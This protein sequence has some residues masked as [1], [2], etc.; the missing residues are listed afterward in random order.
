MEDDFEV[1]ETKKQSKPSWQARR[2]CTHTHLSHA[3]SSAHSAFTAYIAHLHAC[4]THAWFKVTKKVHCIC[5]VSLHLAFSLLMIHLSLLFLHG[6]FGTNP[7][8]DLT[9]SDIHMILPYFSVLKAQ[10][11]RH[12]APASRSLATWPSQMQTQVMNPT[13]STRSLPWMMTRCSSKIRTTISPTSR[14]NAYENIGLFGVPTVFESSV[15]HVSHDDVALQIESK[16]SMQSGNRCWAEGNRSKRRFCD[17]C[18]RIDVKEKSTEQYQELFSSDSHEILTLKSHR[19]S[20][21]EE[22]LRKFFSS[23]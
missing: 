8:N 7:D 21:S 16:E 17:Q 5:V 14:K 12:S 15:S 23:E 1:D 13:S 10:N 22:T 20:C 11:M 2:K 19:K 6:H 9:D 3:H 18:C 4:H